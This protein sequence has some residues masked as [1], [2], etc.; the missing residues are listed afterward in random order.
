MKLP[1]YRLNLAVYYLLLGLWLG[2]LVTF[3][4]AAPN[5]F[6]RM[7]AFAPKMQRTPAEMGEM[8]GNDAQIIA[9]DIVNHILATI[10]PVQ[11]VCAAGL[12][13]LVILQC[14]VFRRW[15][16]RPVVSVANGVRVV[17]LGL[18]VAALVVQLTVLSPRME[19]L[20]QRM[21]HPETGG[22]QRMQL[23]Q[24]FER[25]HTFSE[26]TLGSAAILL[27]GGLLVS[28]FVLTPQAGRA[29]TEERTDHG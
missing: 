28:P 22:D 27:A 26:R 25:Y 10:D 24:D 20:R 16:G 1:L 18:A 29:R 3:A 15:L 4:L 5:I 23:R 8:V 9:G 13:V 17:L 14:T 2:M 11:M 21:Y 7:R 6:I 19:T 12:V